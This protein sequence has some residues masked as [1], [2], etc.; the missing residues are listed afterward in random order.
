MK[1]VI[2]Y[3]KPPNIKVFVNKQHVHDNYTYFVYDIRTLEIIYFIQ[4]RPLLND[5][6]KY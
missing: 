6:D 1:V 3:S 4:S 2:Q 5:F